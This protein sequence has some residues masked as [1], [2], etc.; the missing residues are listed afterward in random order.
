MVIRRFRNDVRFL[1]MMDEMLVVML[2]EEMG[3]REG[4]GKSGQEVGD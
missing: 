3:V 4:R 2:E 1:I